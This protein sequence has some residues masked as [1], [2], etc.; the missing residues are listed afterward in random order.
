MTMDKD[1][2]GKS[3]SYR[4]QYAARYG[5]RLLKAGSILDCGMVAVNKRSGTGV[6][7]DEMFSKVFRP[8]SHVLEHQLI[9]IQTSAPEQADNVSCSLVLGFMDF[10]IPIQF[11][12][13]ISDTLQLFARGSSRESDQ[14][15]KYLHPTH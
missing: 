3:G 1:Q 5:R 11:F 9:N 13:M 10:P 8:F 12:Q 7:A 4:F 6:E 14:P 2:I 15:R